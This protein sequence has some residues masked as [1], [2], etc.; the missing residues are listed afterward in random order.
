M[1]RLEPLGAVGAEG[2]CYFGRFV[3]TGSIAI[4]GA[5]SS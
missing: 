5:L 4:A 1:R 2:M 3:V